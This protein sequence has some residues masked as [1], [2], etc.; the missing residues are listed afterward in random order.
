MIP[1]PFHNII[2]YLLNLIVILSFTDMMTVLSLPGVL[3]IL[4][5]CLH[6]INNAT[7]VSHYTYDIIATHSERAIYNDHMLC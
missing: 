5:Y 7:H 6:D 1:I 3:I 4:L 2:S